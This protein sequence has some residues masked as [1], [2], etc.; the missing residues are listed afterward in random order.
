MFQSPLS[1][2]YVTSVTSLH[3]LRYVVLQERVSLHIEET[4]KVFTIEFGG[5]VQNARAIFYFLLCFRNSEK[6]W[7]F[8][9][10]TAS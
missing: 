9:A 10:A 7:S 3:T 8:N 6:E 2:V 5:L 4:K 1:L